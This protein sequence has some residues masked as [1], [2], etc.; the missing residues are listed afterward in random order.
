MSDISKAFKMDL[1][2]KLGKLAECFGLEAI[3]MGEDDNIAFA[4]VGCLSITSTPPPALHIRRKKDMLSIMIRDLASLGPNNSVTNVAVSSLFR[5][6]AQ[7]L[8]GKEELTHQTKLSHVLTFDAFTS[9]K[10]TVWELMA[11]ITLEM[12][13][14]HIST[15]SVVNFSDGEVYVD[16]AMDCD[17][18]S[19]PDTVEDRIQNLL[20]HAK[21][22]QD[23]LRVVR[24]DISNEPATADELFQ[25]VSSVMEL[26]KS[27]SDNNASA[28]DEVSGKKGESCM[29]AATTGI[30]DEDLTL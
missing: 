10:K 16:T 26:Q 1:I 15:R 7:M 8:V 5:D 20:F 9:R 24:R 27:D 22:L 18:E 3:E 11:M 17:F 28:G 12:N 2:T 19:A 14:Y 4:L 6:L 25:E 23:I 29:V 21:L 13:N 30:E